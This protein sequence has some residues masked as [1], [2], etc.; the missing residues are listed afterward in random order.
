MF[1]VDWKEM[2]GWDGNT[3]GGEAH[4][5]ELGQG[6]GREPPLRLLQRLPIGV[7]Y[8]ELLAPSWLPICPLVE[9]FGPHV[10][11]PFRRVLWLPIGSLSEPGPL[12]P[13]WLPISPAPLCSGLALWHTVLAPYLRPDSPPYVCPGKFREIS[14]P[15]R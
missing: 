3:N 11:C 7:P 14:C 4:W 12:A 6:F 10:D 9:P 1:L 5:E 8:R 13:C 2:P 15:I